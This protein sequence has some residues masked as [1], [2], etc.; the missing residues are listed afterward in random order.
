MQIQDFRKKVCRTLFKFLFF[1]V[2]VFWISKLSQLLLNGPRKS[3]NWLELQEIFELDTSENFLAW[4]APAWENKVISVAVILALFLCPFPLSLEHF[5]LFP[6]AFHSL[7]S[8]RMKKELHYY[9][10]ACGWRNWSGDADS[11]ELGDCRDDN[12]MLNLCVLIFVEYDYISVHFISPFK[13][14]CSCVMIN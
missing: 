5:F 1:Y 14:L 13:H 11:R 4:R 6:P 8:A 2:A 7:I 10:L 3:W 9:E 12:L